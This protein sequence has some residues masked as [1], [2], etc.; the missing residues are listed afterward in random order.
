MRLVVAA[1]QTHLTAVHVTSSSTLTRVARL[2]KGP[3]IGVNG[4]EYWCCYC[5]IA[6]L[7]ELAVMAVD[8]AKASS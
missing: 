5:A 4:R 6:P 1:S 8:M 2:A 3:C 7:T